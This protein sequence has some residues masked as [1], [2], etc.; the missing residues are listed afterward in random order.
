M[1]VAFALIAGAWWRYRTWLA[2]RFRCK[3]RQAALRALEHM[4]ENALKRVLK[5][6][7]TSSDI[8]LQPRPWV[9]MQSYLLRARS[10]RLSIEVS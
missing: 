8:C 2:A 6:V 10:E 3:E 1:L 7:C 5:D 4:D 9:G